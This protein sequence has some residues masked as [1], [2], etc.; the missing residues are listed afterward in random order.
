[1][2]HDNYDDREDDEDDTEEEER[3]TDAEAQRPGILLR[4]MINLRRLIRVAVNDAICLGGRIQ[5][6][7]TH[8]KMSERIKRKELAKL[9]RDISLLLGMV[10][11]VEQTL[12]AK[13]D[14]LGE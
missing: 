1:M 13:I 8:K 9:K 3:R 6:E 2:V 14:R 11:R 12:D 7:A 5:Y 4:N 10:E